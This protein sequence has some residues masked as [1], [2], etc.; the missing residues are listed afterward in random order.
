MLAQCPLT[1]INTS[2]N[3]N[4][5]R[6]GGATGGAGLQAGRGGATGGDV[7]RL[8]SF[9]EKVINCEVVMVYSR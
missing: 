4:Q 6:Q 3:Y 8:R 9:P 5:H 7:S 2:I 1:V